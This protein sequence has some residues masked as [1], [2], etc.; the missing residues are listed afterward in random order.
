M[1]TMEYSTWIRQTYHVVDPPNTWDGRVWCFSKMVPGKMLAEWEE[2]GY[3]PEWMY[4]RYLKE[5]HGIV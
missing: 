5:R 4:E 2:G 3:T 1:A